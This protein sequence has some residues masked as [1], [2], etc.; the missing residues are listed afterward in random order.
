MKIEKSELVIFAVYAIVFAYAIAI[1]FFR[2]A[3]PLSS[4]FVPLAIALFIIL[5]IHIAN[6]FLRNSI[7][8]KVSS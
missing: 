5:I 7:K 4:V 6:I 2:I 8:E 1:H 3:L